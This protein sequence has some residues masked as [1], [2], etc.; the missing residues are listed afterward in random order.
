MPATASRPLRRDAQRNRERIVAAAR[1]VFATRGFA[2]TLDDVAHHA[3]VGVGTVYRRFP[4]KEALVEA[5]FADRIEGVVAV[6]EQCLAEPSAW[7]GLTRFMVYA[8]HTHAEDRG[9]RDVMLSLGMKKRFPD[10]GDRLETVITELV[11]RAKDE[12]TLRTDFEATDVPIIFTMVSDLAGAPA[13][14]Y[15]RYLRLV[16][17]GLRACPRNADLGPALTRDQVIGVLSG[18]V[19]PVR[20]RSSAAQ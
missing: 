3:G 15:D 2:A 12:G 17:D 11:A 7:D 14:A 13:G 20:P 18:C 10:S 8:C 19:P 4:T 16:I 5:I 6:A 1:E 9:L